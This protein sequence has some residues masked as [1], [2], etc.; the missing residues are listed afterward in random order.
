MRYLLPL[1][2]PEHVHASLLLPDGTAT[3]IIYAT[4]IAFV[5]CCAAGL[6]QK[7]TLRM[8]PSTASDIY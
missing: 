1:L 2:P 8:H 7:A 5:I 4:N 3:V 6:V